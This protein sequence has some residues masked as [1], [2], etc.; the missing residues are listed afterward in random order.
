MSRL[1]FWSCLAL[2]LF[3]W[4]A[5][6]ADPAAQSRD[7]FVM[8]QRAMAANKPAEALAAFQ[9]SYK[10]S[11]APTVLFFI[12]EAQQAVGQEGKALATYEEY[13]AKLPNAP[14]KAEAQAQVA[15][16]KAKGVTTLK[17]EIAE[18]DLEGAPK[19]AASK[20]AKPASAADLSL[21]TGKLAAEAKPAGRGGKKLTKLERK[22][23]AAKEAEEKAASERA[24]AVKAAE[25]K[26]VMEAAAA[27]RAA[28]LSA[29]ESKA[30][31][32][33]AAAEAK[34]MEVKP[35]EPTPVP[36]KAAAP[37][38]VSQPPTYSAPPERSAPAEAE[39]GPWQFSL[40]AGFA[41]GYLQHT[42]FPTSMF[43]TSDWDLLPMESLDVA[44][45]YRFGRVSLGLFGEVAF[46]G[47]PAI[48]GNEL[49]PVISV[50][51]RVEFELGSVFRLGVFGS[52][53]LIPQ[54]D[55]LSLNFGVGGDVGV[56]FG[57]WGVRLGTAYFTGT[58]SYPV[59]RGAAFTSNSVSLVPVT[60]GLHW[61]L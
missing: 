36:P 42:A 13:L 31:A 50:G 56:Q 1:R 14:K 57:H 16:L 39:E 3:V 51:P 53:V 47:K 32:E 33:K 12:A 11:N 45:A 17:I 20:K 59:P 22:M 27:A 5:S 15:A 34:A 43:T 26:S 24:A 23:A 55:T 38:A 19:A 61:V 46:A 7:L 48:F 44:I 28:E 21:D 18:L 2:L 30:S 40:T 58:S 52:R 49:L 54:Q 10:V 41:V 35:V 60:L 6:A 9:A 8:G 37:I 4:T 25:E 29:A